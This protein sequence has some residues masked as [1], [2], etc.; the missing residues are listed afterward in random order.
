M[1]ILYHLTVL[2][3]IVYILVQSKFKNKH[4]AHFT[5]L[6][7]DGDHD[8]RYLHHCMLLLQNIAQL[9]GL[10]DLEMRIN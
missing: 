5:F 8:V 9:Q 10:G 6:F 4:H 2:V 3:V 1:R 7:P